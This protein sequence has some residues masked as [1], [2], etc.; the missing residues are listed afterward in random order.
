MSICILAEIFQYFSK[1]TLNFDNF[2]SGSIKE[3]SHKIWRY[4]GI[5]LS[6]KV[7]FVTWLICLVNSSIES[8]LTQEICL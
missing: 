2:W 8:N 3:I 5:D 6:E 7:K 4:A 1:A